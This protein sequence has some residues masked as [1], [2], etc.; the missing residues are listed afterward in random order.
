MLPD[1]LRLIC[2]MP[3]LA[4]RQQDGTQGIELMYL[5]VTGRC[6]L[7]AESGFSQ[8]ECGENCAASPAANA[9]IPAACSGSAHRKF[10]CV[11]KG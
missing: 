4:R 5:L 1:L 9:P 10:H 2:S 7:A 8:R 3:Q 6:S 11:L